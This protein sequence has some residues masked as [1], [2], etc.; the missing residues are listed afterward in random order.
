MATKDY[1]N[2]KPRGP[3]KPK[4]LRKPK[5]K[6]SKR[7]S[8][9][10]TTIVV[11]AVAGFAYFLWS[12]ESSA[13]E[14]ES[15]PAAK[16]KPHKNPS[17]LPP[18][19]KEEWAY[20]KELE[21]KQVEVDLPKPSDKPTKPYQIQCASFRLES[22]ADEMKAKIAFQGLEAQVRRVQGSS[23][24]WYKVVLG[25]F[26]R[27]RMAEKKRHVLQRGGINGCQIWLW[28]G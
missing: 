3:N 28:E 20:L 1:A 24:V 25:P 16:V 13:P 2:R 23:G 12:L 5:N 6:Q 7:V 26:E 21:N 15:K 22:Q 19:P 4:G 8:W 10:F 9:L 11:I 14:Q 27:K 18:K 17:A